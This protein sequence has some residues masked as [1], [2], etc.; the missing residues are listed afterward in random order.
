[1]NHGNPPSVGTADIPD[2]SRVAFFDGQRLTAGDLNGAAGVQRELRWLHNRSLHNWGIGLGFAVRG[3]KGDHQVQVGPGYA[4]D[5]R[6]REILLTEPLQKAVPARADDGHGQPVRYYLVAAYPDD[7]RLAV[8]ERRQGECGTEGAVRLQER[9]AIYWKAEGEQTVETG[10][11]IVLA[12]ATVQNCQLAAPLS[13]DQRRSARPLR[14]P[15]VAAGTTR[16]G[17]TPWEAWTIS[18]DGV[19]TVLGVKAT[20]DTSVGRFGATPE[21]QAQLQGNRLINA[22]GTGVEGAFLLLEGMTFVSAPSRH[23]FDF[24][25][26]MPRGLINAFGSIPVNPNR[27]FVSA[28]ELVQLIRANWSVAWVGVEG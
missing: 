26:L 7:A 23:G 3:A 4:L 19:A 18:A 12:L 15:F 24:Y 2:L 16:L 10:L 17:D 13:L 25:V 14:Q 20:L 21:Y 6:G 8:L 28:I 27:L 5:C 9:A 1:M 11:E 22:D